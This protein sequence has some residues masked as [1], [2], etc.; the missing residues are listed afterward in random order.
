M[1]FK[2]KKLDSLCRASVK[3][4]YMFIKL[5]L[6]EKVIGNFLKLLMSRLMFWGEAVEPVPSVSK[7]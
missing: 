6:T 5:S 3:R 4:Q 7:D 1:D 2:S